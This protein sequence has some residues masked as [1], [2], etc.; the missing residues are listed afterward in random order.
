M[1]HYDV[2]VL[3]CGPGGE[4]AAIQAAKAGRSVGVVERAEVV[5]GNRV[6]WGTIPSKTL[7]ESAVF[8]LNLT[9][10]K[11]DG[12]RVDIA[13]EITVADFM[14]RERK[15]VHREL[16]LINESLDRYR[17]EIIEG[18]GR[19][20]DPHTVTVTARDGTVRESLTGEVIVIATG[21]RP[22]RPSDLHFD[23]ELVFD[24]DSILHLPKMPRSM[25]VLGAGVIGI[26]YASIFAALGIRITL[27][28][29]RGRLLPYFDRE[30]V[31]ILERELERLG[32]VTSHNDRYE[33]IE[34]V[35]YPRPHVLCHTSRGASLEA[36]V[37]LYCVGRDGNTDDIGLDRI[38]LEANRYGLLE[39]NEAYQ[40]SYP[41][42]YAVGDVIGY[43]A[44][45]ST[46]M[47]QGRRAIRHA[48]EI[49]GPSVAGDELPFAIYSIPE[50]SYIGATEEA[51]A[52]QGVA[53]VCGRGNYDMNARGQII[54]DYAGLLKLLFSV[55][56]LELLG[57]HVVGS[58]AS[59]LIHIGQAFLRSRSTARAIA[60]T[61]FNYPTLSDCY[62][63]AAQAALGEYHRR[64]GKP[65]WL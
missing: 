65:A 36:D 31:G 56:T 45:A 1:R 43:P 18:Q 49:P 58:R 17:V 64:T 12:I 42:I 11:M 54:G 28:D 30:I 40:T 33:T 34:R 25:I 52:E 37:L 7:R 10:N 39:V 62:R 27:V 14:Y 50:V 19:F 22:H 46:S 44:L 61:L 5:G 60:E 15:V 47:E 32:V 41:H 6:N 23:G 13:E 21:S 35:S 59:E 38:G 63:H 2:I 4:R 53:Y 29:T 26:E 57:V 9:R 24:S 51:L 3:G 16:E 20:A 55:E 48:F 8:V